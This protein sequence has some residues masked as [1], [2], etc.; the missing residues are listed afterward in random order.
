MNFIGAPDRIGGDFECTGNK[1][2]SL[3]GLP[4]LIMGNFICNFDHEFKITEDDVRRRS[5]VEGRVMLYRK[6][7]LDFDW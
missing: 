5:E 6:V 3:D 2:T 7:D 4:K 1:I